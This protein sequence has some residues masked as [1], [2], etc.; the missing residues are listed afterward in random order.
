LA[1][2]P[3]LPAPPMLK[4]ACKGPSAAG[5]TAACTP[6]GC[7]Q[8]VRHSDVI[9]LPSQMN[10]TLRLGWSCTALITRASRS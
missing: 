5:A 4:K 8:R 3:P 7:D 9:A 2:R 6:L 1:P 10:R